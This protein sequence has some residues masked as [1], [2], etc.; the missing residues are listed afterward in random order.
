MTRG[1]ADALTVHCPGADPSAAPVGPTCRKRVRLW[2]PGAA[3][4]LACRAALLRPLP[5]V[6]T[7]ATRFAAE[8]L[9]RRASLEPRPAPPVVAHPQPLRIDVGIAQVVVGVG[10]LVDA[11]RQPPPSPDPTT[12]RPATSGQGG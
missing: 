11:A 3:L 6:L 5:L 1:C 10:R 8:P 7:A 4:S 2:E 12:L 9:V